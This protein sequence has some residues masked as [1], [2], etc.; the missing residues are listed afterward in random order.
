[1][2]YSKS[3]ITALKLVEAVRGFILYAL[4]DNIHPIAVPAIMAIGNKLTCSPTLM[5]QGE[6]ALS[7]RRP[8]DRMRDLEVDLGKVPER[9]AS[10]VSKSLGGVKAFFAY[11]CT[12]VVVQGGGSY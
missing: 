9:I 6:D 3:T 1:M 11:L 5:G 10:T 4:R 2:M 8:L 7:L 12:Q